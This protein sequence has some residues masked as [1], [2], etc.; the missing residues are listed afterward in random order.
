MKTLGDEKGIVICDDQH[1]EFCH[2]VWPIVCHVGC[3]LVHF[4]GL[5]FYIDWSCIISSYHGVLYIAGR[6]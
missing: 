1:G 4:E 5:K 6:V 2:L 3:I